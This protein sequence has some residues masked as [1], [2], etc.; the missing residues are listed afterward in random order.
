MNIKLI[1][2]SITI[3]VFAIFYLCNVRKFI[4]I[5][6]YPKA[7]LN[8]SIN[9]YIQCMGNR[10][11]INELNT[12][13]SIIEKYKIIKRI[14]KDLVYGKKL[15]YFRLPAKITKNP[16]EGYYY[17]IKIFN[18]KK[19]L[20]KDIYYAFDNEE[21]QKVTI[22]TDTLLRFHRNKI[23]QKFYLKIN[24]NNIYENLLI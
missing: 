17:Y 2:D 13:Y 23:V 5:V 6:N 22:I 4:K 18:Y 9:E 12:E 20:S 1:I 21:I 8:E 7:N 14:Q 11:I 19:K 16:R 3:F 10:D 15:Q 24:E